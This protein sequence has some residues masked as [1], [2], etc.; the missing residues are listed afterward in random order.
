MPVDMSETIG[1]L[2]MLSNKFIQR[3]TLEVNGNNGD[4]I[5]FEQ[6]QLLELYDEVDEMNCD[7]IIGHPIIKEIW[8]CNKNKEK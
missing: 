2:K 5:S 8:D 7:P 3:T 1:L 4:G 6:V